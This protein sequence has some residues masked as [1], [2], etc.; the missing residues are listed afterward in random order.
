MR[1]VPVSTGVVAILVALLAAGF[2]AGTGHA[3]DRFV[4]A[5]DGARVVAEQRIAP[6]RLDLTIDSPALGTTAH[7]RLLT[8]DGW[9]PGRHDWPSLWLLHGCCGGYTDWTTYSDVAQLASLRRVLVVMP[10]AGAAGWYSDWWNYGRGGAPRWET[11][12]TT[13][14][15][16]IVE[17]GYGAGGRRVAAG[18]SMGGFGALSYAAGHPGLFRAVASFSGT[19]HPLLQV[20]GGPGPDWFLNLDRTQGVDP[21]AVWGDPVR[22]RTV[23][24]AHDPTVRAGAL[25]R[26]PL[27][28][29]CG[30]GEAGPYDAAGAKD[31]NEA[32]F[33][34]QN[35]ALADRLGALGSPV[36]TDFYGPGTHA[37]PYWERE[38][39]RSLPMLLAAL[40]G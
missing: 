40:A 38:L 14:V 18:L 25:R 27:F 17:R 32:Y 6:N 2:G 35:R 33:E 37:W 4:R 10:E 22:Q 23:W 16:Q 31:P 34:R 1:R 19:V 15:R 12:H 13:E 11:F 5:D 8:P 36:L 39:H 20:P 28:L 3:R 9:S 7:V 29:S 30:N 26:L 21:Y 24:A